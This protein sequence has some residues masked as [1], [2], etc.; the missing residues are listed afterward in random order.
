MIA[1]Y[2]FN[3]FEKLLPVE[4]ELKGGYPVAS[5]L[6]R[7]VDDVDGKEKIAVEW[8]LDEKGNYNGRRASRSNLKKASSMEPSNTLQQV[9]SKALARLTEKIT[10]LSER[11]KVDNRKHYYNYA[12]FADT[13]YDSM[14][15][16]GEGSG[17]RFLEHLGILKFFMDL[18]LLDSSPKYTKFSQKIQEH[19]GISLVLSFQ[20]SILMSIA[21]S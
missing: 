1:G 21:F 11:Y 2:K 4:K 10:D 13:S 8:A 17:Y 15:Y 16:A 6:P 9:D 12:Y 3:G 5:P 7:T 18:K 14:F 20:I 19:G